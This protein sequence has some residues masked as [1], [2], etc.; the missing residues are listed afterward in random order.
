MKVKGVPN[1]QSHLVYRYITMCVSIRHT[2]CESLVKICLTKHKCCS[3]W[4]YVFQTWGSV[5]I[6]QQNKVLVIKNPA[7]LGTT[8]IVYLTF[9]RYCRPLYKL[10]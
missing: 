6:L 10:G 9:S 4:G 5:L 2:F 1:L 7:T 3:I 8:R